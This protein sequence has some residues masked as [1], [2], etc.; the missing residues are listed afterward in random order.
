MNYEKMIQKRNEIDKKIKSIHAQLKKLPEGK[1]ICAR[2]GKYYKWYKSDGKKKIYLP[3]T[4]RKLAEQ[5]AYKNYLNF[6]LSN[7]KNEKKAIEAYLKHYDPN[8]IQKEISFLTSPGYKELLNPFFQHQIQQI[9]EWAQAPYEK[10]NKYPEKLIH[11]TVSGNVVRSKSEVLIDMVLYKNKIPF[12]Y[13]CALK[14][15]EKIIYPDF[16]I[17][18]PKTG[19]LIFWEHFGLMDDAT[20]SKNAFQ[21]LQLYTSNGIIPSIHLITTYETKENPLNVEDIEKIVEHYFK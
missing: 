21:K 7:L 4:E 20:Y 3:K 8:A 1:F 5:L 14:L 2:N 13:E 11:K 19:Q 9:S 17:C 12:R 18:H 6:Q 10:S 16:T 15:K